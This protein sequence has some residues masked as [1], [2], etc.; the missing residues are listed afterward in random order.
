LFLLRA[1]DSGFATVGARVKVIFALPIFLIWFGSSIAMA[2]TLVWGSTPFPPGYITEG[3]EKGQGYAD[4]L[5]RFMMEKL[6]QYDHK[7][8]ESPNWERQLR[9]MK[10]GPLVCTSILWYRPPDQ[11]ASL[12]G[13]Y[14]L[15]APDGVFFQHDLVVHK[16]KRHLFGDEV[17]FA[18]LLRK[19]K[20]KFGY[21]RPYGIT[22]NRLLADYVGLAPGV[23]LDAMDPLARSQALRKTENIFVRSGADMIPGMLKMLLKDRVDYAL[24]YEFMVKYQRSRMGFGNELVSIPV[25]EVKGK[26]SR[27][28]YACSDT[29]QGEKAIAAINQV[30][31][32]YRATDEFKNYLAYLV[33]EG[34]EDIYWKEYEKILDVLQ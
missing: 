19:P 32:K 25:T 12:K 8:V 15:S 33:P 6:P 18:E 30:L 17:S 20:L 14:L 31:R 22:F 16:S 4:R 7:I 9:M 1:G 21:N 26:I 23:E 24:E 34:R 3:P 29:P 28:A 27:T 13:A 10:N 5:D 11:R 2:E